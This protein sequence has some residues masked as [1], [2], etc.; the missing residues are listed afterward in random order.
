MG[1]NSACVTWTWNVA[2]SV[3]KACLTNIGYLALIIQH[4]NL[5][6]NIIDMM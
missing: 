1:I 4:T 3:F 2:M 6:K 5:K